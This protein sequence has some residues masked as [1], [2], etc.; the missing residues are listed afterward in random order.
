[1]MG[2]PEGPK[3]FKIG[4]D[5]YTKYRRVTDKHPDRHVST[6]KTALMHCVARVKT[7]VLGVTCRPLQ[8]VFLAAI[9]DRA[10]ETG[11]ERVPRKF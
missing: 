4:L 1:M 5:V 3:C 2:L 9:G 10:T 6:A 8:G 11:D 7:L